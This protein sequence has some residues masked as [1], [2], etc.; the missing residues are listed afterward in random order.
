MNHMRPRRIKNL[1]ARGPLRR[2]RCRKRRRRSPCDTAPHEQTE[3]DPDPSHQAT[4]QICLQSRPH[5]VYDYFPTVPMHHKFLSVLTNICPL[6]I[7]I[8]ACVFSPSG[9]LASALAWGPRPPSRKAFIDSFPP[10]PPDVK[11]IPFPI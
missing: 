4:P 5:K 1:P 6:E 9:L 8:D 10:H 2:P 7:A 3:D 11:A